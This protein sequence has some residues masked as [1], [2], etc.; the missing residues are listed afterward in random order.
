MFQP[1]YLSDVRIPLALRV[2]QVPVKKDTFEPTA[3]RVVAPT[4]Q[5]AP[6]AAVVGPSGAAAVAAPA[7]GTV[8]K[9]WDAITA[10]AAA[11]R[12][13]TARVEDIPEEVKEAVRARFSGDEVT[14]E[15]ERLIMINWLYEHIQTSET[16]EP[17]AKQSYLNALATVLLE[18]VWDE[19]L[20]GTEQHALIRKGGE[21]AKSAASE[22]M[23]KKSSTEAFRFVDPITGIL[24][25]IC[26]EGACSEAVRRVLDSDVADPL[27]Q[28]Q[29]NRDVTGG[30]YGFLVPKSKEGRLIFKT[31]DRPPAP[32]GKPEK[33]GECA[34]VSTISYHIKMLKDIG[35]LMTAEGFPRFIVTDD[36]L[37]EKTRRK[38]EKEEAK[39]AGRKSVATPARNPRR[40]FE[41]ALRACALKDII[42]RWMTVMTAGRGGGAAAGQPRR[43]FYRPVAALKTGHKGIIAK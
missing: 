26:G 42:L 22:Q 24:R 27:N 37:D 33:G 34:I 5:A 16:Y 35:E 25:Y 1:D 40:S 41:N 9:F 2:A 7:S 36:I 43:Y 32:G 10:W 3:I 29:V 12:G 6:A 28:L 31:S 20:R 8:D 23:I 30:I 19:S 38:K 18:F 13:Q 21:A 4:G 14:R 39:A 11:I 15:S 17:A